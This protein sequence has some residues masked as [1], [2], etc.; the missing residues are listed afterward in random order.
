MSDA[1]SMPYLN[2]N[3]GTIEAVIV[4][5]FHC[6]VSLFF[7]FHMLERGN[8]IKISRWLGVSKVTY[9]K[10]ILANDITMRHF[11]IRTEE[12]FKLGILG[13]DGQ[14]TNKEFG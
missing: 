10:A 3:V 14:S 11:P 12:L 9:H 7:V 2:C 1:I 13:S 8:H 6:F 5:I 4:Q